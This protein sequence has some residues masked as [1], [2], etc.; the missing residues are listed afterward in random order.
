MS[1]DAPVAQRIALA[2]VLDLD[3]FGAEVRELQAQHVAGDEAREIEHADA[4]ERA[5]GVGTEGA[6]SGMIL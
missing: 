5:F 3:H 4:V 1:F 2:R 6:H